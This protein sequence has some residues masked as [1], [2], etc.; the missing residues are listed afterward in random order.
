MDKVEVRYV[1]GPLDGTTGEY[2]QPP[3]FGLRV[4]NARRPIMAGEVVTEDDMEPG[5]TLY[6]LSESPD[7][8]Q[9]YWA[10]PNG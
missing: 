9:Y 4:A 10:G 3:P 7:G 1:G 6:L 2:E 5:G 8:E